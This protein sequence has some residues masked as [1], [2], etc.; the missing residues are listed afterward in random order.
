LEQ[1]GSEMDAKSNPSAEMDAIS[2]LHLTFHGTRRCLAP[3]TVIGPELGAHSCQLKAKFGVKRPPLI[4]VLSMLSLPSSVIIETGDVRIAEDIGGSRS[5]VEY[6]KG[7]C[8]KRAVK[9]ALQ[10]SSTAETW[11]ELRSSCSAG[12]KNGCA[13]I[14]SGRFCVDLNV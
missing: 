12:S 7:F 14:V 6:M 3:V 11:H 2:I 13:K 5:P 9:R 4:E 8:A 1:S 10:R